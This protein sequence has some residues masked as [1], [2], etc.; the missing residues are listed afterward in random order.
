MLGCEGLIGAALFGCVASNPACLPIELRPL[1]PVLEAIASQESGFRPNA[2]RDETANQSMFPATR[3]EAER[4]AAE[5]LRKGAVVGAG[6]FQITH[7]SNWARHG[8]DVKTAFDPCLNLRAGA[9]HFSGDLNAAMQRYNS[10]RMNGA[11]GYAAS[12]LARLSRVKPTET[13]PPAAQQNAAPAQEA[14][15]CP[16]APPAWDAWG[17]ARHAA[18]C[19]RL[20]ALRTQKGHPTP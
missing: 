12:V 16:A 4:I 18:A 20:V 9:A 14:T 10:G 15:P 5:R 11:P 19:G 13:P 1:R 2:L 3:A 7:A 8:L 6:W 17:T